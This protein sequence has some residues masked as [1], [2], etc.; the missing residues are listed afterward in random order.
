MMSRVKGINFWY[1]I[2]SAQIALDVKVKQAFVCFYYN[3][4]TKW[5]VLENV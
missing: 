5:N 2:I 3:S 4:E 1:V